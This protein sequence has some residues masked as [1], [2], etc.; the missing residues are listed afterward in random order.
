MVSVGGR[1]R[2]R[3]LRIVAF[4]VIE[5]WGAFGRGEVQRGEKP[6]ARNFFE[7]SAKVE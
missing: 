5:P 4:A 1:R 2:V 6:M 3:P 7:E